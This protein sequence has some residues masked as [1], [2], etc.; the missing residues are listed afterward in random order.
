MNKAVLGIGLLFFM[1]FG[2][3]VAAQTD[4]FAP[5][6]V[7]AFADWLFG[8]G[9]Y[10]RA[11]AEYY[12]FFYES[13]GIGAD[14]ILR[15]I[16]LCYFRAANY[17]KAVQVYERLMRD[18]PQSRFIEEVYYEAAYSYFKL[19]EFALSSATIGRYGREA[20]LLPPFVL[21]DGAASLLAG[22]AERARFLLDEYG[23]M[24][25]AMDREK[26]AAISGLID[27][28]GQTPSRS[29]VLAGILSTFL[30]GIGKMYA[31]RIEDGIFSLILC[32]LFGGLAAY[33][34]STDGVESVPG[35][36]YASLGGLFYLGDIWGSVMAAIQFNDGQK[37]SVNR[38][39]M[40][41]LHEL[42]P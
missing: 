23:R 9:E 2:G 4:P 40:E 27:E 37:E 36:I 15:K 29:P 3:R 26:A 19:N 20:E 6:S 21:L 12:R 38:G 31:N 33:A 7:L 17:G 14:G 22:D 10:E 13:G 42:F 41:R 32:G 16:G 1:V 35:W 28:L 18:H 5:Q 34:F 8:E 30:P 25:T 11:A 39:I 24:P